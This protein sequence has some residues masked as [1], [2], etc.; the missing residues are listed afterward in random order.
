MKSVLQDNI[1]EGRYLEPLH[2][3]SGVCETNKNSISN[4]KNWKN[5]L[6]KLKLFEKYK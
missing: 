2:S 4:K 6:N 1:D 5:N 3:C